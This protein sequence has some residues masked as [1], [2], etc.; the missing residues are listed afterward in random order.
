MRDQVPGTY[1]LHEF[2]L[3]ASRCRTPR[4]FRELLEQLKTILPYRHL[5]CGWGYRRSYS[6][7]FIFNHSYPR[8][9]VRWFLSRGILSE[10]PMFR[11]WLRERRPQILSKTL[12]GRVEDR[13]RVEVITRFGLNHSLGGGSLGQEV[14]VYFALTMATEDDCTACLDRFRLIVPILVRALRRSCPRPLLTRREKTILEH[15]ALGEPPKRIA[16][17]LGM[18]ER[19]AREHLQQIKKKLYTDDL[20]NA[21]VIALR[22]GMLDQK[23]KEVQWRRSWRRA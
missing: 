11:A 1:A 16:E 8:D 22:T 20:V 21:V 18:A 6:I 12:K 15:R 17:T 4:Q 5:M 14:W 9:F 7:A 13:E 3:T 19:T 2:T 10:G 23:W